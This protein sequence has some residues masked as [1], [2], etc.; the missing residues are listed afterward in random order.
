MRYRWLV[1]ALLTPLWVA[2]SSWLE[3]S[4]TVEPT[5]L[6]PFSSVQPLKTLWSVSMGDDI[7]EGF[8]PA[9]HRGSIVVADRH[10]SIDVLDALNGR[11]VSHFSLARELISGVAVVG[12][13]ALVGTRDGSLVAVQLA[14]GKIA[15]ERSLTSVMLEAPAIGDT[16]AVV[17]TNDG[18][19]TGFSVQDGTQL[20]SMGHLQP[21]LIVHNTGSM[22]AIGNDVVMVGMPA[23]KILV[24]S[25]TSGNV[26]WEAVV[27]YP[28]GATELERMTD[29]VS[30]PV[31]DDKQVCAVAYQGRVA[32]F[33]AQWGSLQWA[34]EVSSSRGLTLDNNNVY[35]T[36]EDGVVFAFSRADGR[37]VWKTEALKYRDVSGPVRLGHRILVVD[38]EGYAHVLSDENG[39]LLGR[40]HL[41]GKGTIGQPVSFG[42]SVLVQSR[43]GRLT[44]LSLG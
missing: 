6:K 17:R 15:W 38:G 5:P 20:W 30:A 18:R 11:R 27:A 35:V 19:L 2:C 3:S 10:G 43:N 39:K 31:F 28:N 14:T 21:Q 44:L 32:C 37:P 1:M 16:V 7:T 29:V 34:R 33:D 23:G 36:D 8:V 26:L 25:Q 42:D 12:G 22:R 41:G 4:P 24:A 40:S 13:N 9:Y